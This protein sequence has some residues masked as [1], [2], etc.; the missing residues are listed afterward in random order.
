MSIGKSSSEVLFQSKNT[1]A[2]ILSVVS[3][4]NHTFSSEVL[5]HHWFSPTKM[6]S[7]CCSSG[8]S[9]TTCP[10]L[11]LGS[12]ITHPLMAQRTRYRDKTR[13]C[14]HCIYLY[15]YVYLYHTMGLSNAK[16]MFLLKFS[17]MWISI[18]IQNLNLKCNFQSAR[19]FAN[20]PILFE[21]WNGQIFR[22]SNWQV[23]APVNPKSPSKSGKL[24]LTIVLALFSCSQPLVQIWK[25]RNIFLLRVFFFPGLKS[26]EK[27]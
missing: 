18:T 8:K 17:N 23:H 14:I 10:S 11:A 6:N 27:G 22:Y 25:A 9:Q 16:N 1:V 5:F 15:V 24:L 19:D 26:F 2:N 13:C 12:M 21:P 4:E 20:G 3:L 7:E